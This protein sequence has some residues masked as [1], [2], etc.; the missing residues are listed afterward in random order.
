MLFVP[1][2]ANSFADV[3]SSTGT[4][5]PAPSQGTAV[6]P[7]VGAK[8]AWVQVI[9]SLSSDTYG[10]LICINNNNASAAS[11]NTRLDIGVGAASSE[12]VLIPDLIAGNAAAYSVPG[13]GIWYYFPVAIPAGTRVSARAQSTV[14][15]SF[16]VFL[17]AMQ[18]PFN[19]S[20]L[21]KASFVEVV[22]MAWPSGTALTPGTTNKSSWVLLGTTSQRC[23]WWQIGAQ[24]TSSDTTHNAGIIHLDLAVGNGT[25]YNLILRD[26]GLS[27]TG[28]EV[29][30]MTPLTIGCE[31][32]VPA[33]SNIYARAQHSATPDDL[34]VAAYGAGG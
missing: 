11:R 27:V 13:S 6:T 22:G 3:Q 20:M 8:G 34:L 17:Q 23:W 1:A 5:R 24:V 19:P 15:T 4:A 21:K 2:G 32:P 14:T 30:T 12:I 26:V 28:A 31:F 29:A 7:D 25:D 10:L 18:G 33:G 9:A 16:R